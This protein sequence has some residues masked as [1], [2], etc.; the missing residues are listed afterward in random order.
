MSINQI[1]NVEEKNIYFL[2]YMIRDNI[3]KI[4]FHK[5]KIILHPKKIKMIGVE[6][7]CAIVVPHYLTTRDNMDCHSLIQLRLRVLEN[8]S[9]I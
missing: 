1:L 6:R 7:R 5:K 4:V 2:K 9:Q 8:L 3:A